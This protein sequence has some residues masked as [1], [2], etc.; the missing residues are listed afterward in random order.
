MSPSVFSNMATLAEQQID[1]IFDTVC[2][3]EEQG[4][5][6]IHPRA[7]SQN[8]WREETLQ[9]AKRR[10][11]ALTTKSWYSG[12]NVPGKPQVFM[13]YCGGFKRYHDAC[14]AEVEGGFP[15]YELLPPAVST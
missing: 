8:R 3:L 10:P 5:A 15:S 4:R 11:G 9:S 1:F 12:A 2:W 7:E 6:G 13:V 14:S